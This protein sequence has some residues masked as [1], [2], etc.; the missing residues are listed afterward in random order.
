MDDS[1]P[2]EKMVSL[3]DIQE[4]SLSR[5]RPGAKS[6]SSSGSR[7][8]GRP[9]G[10][11]SCLLCKVRRARGRGNRIEA[12]CTICKFKRLHEIRERPKIVC[13][14]PPVRAEAA[15]SSRGS[16]NR[17]GS[18]EQISAPPAGNERVKE[19]LMGIRADGENIPYLLDEASIAPP[20]SISESTYAEAFLAQP[21][22]PPSTTSNHS[23]ESPRFS[24]RPVSPCL[25]GWM[26]S[27]PAR[28]EPDEVE[29]LQMKGALS[30]PDPNI[31]EAIIQAYVEFVHYDLP[32]LDLQEFLDTISTGEGE[33]RRVSLL[34]FQAIIFAGSAFVDMKCLRNAGFRTRREAR[35][36][37]YNKVRLLYDFDYETDSTNLIQ[38]LLLMTYWYESP[39]DLKGAWHWTGLAASLCR[40]QKLHESSTYINLDTTKQRR[41]KRIWWSC[42][43]RD[44]LVA[45]GTRRP[46][47]IKFEE[48][49]ISMLAMDD[50]NF[51]SA[52]ERAGARCAFGVGKEDASRQQQLALLCIEKVKLCVCIGNILLTQYHIS[53]RHVGKEGP[54]GSEDAT[55]TL[56]PNA[57]DPSHFKSCNDQLQAWSAMLPDVAIY[58]PFDVAGDRLA[59]RSIAAH[60]ALLQMLF[61]TASMTL[62]RP[63]A[64]SG[65][66][67]TE[68]T[69]GAQQQSK[70]TLAGAADAI[71]AIADDLLV[72]DLVW[73]L[74][75]TG[76]TVIASYLATNLLDTTPTDNTTNQK[77]VQQFS[78][79]L[80]AMRILGE[81][82]KA[83]LF[84]IQCVE[85]ATKKRSAPRPPSVMKP[86]PR[87]SRSCNF[88][89]GLSF[90]SIL[91]DLEHLIPPTHAQ[92]PAIPALASGPSVSL[93]TIECAFDSPK[94]VVVMLS[95]AASPTDESPELTMADFSA[96]DPEVG[97]S[98]DFSDSNIVCDEIFN[99]MI[100]FGEPETEEGGVTDSPDRAIRLLGIEEG[101]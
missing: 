10:D 92:A 46:L 72:N 19:G 49:D 6:K 23:A 100:D 3:S 78:I 76:V 7:I 59:T 58:R 51:E 21:V 61:H 35:E 64:L 91:D 28:F 29:F 71:A 17:E 32:V 5:S 101:S 73:Y 62:H 74:P 8:Q 86:Q 36:V 82:Y 12:F 4:Q 67:E 30:I 99:T 47:H 94:D 16:R 98:L 89:P 69:A 63:R 22:S 75:S 83:A 88:G 53:I 79:G 77:R 26:S 80:N 44:R 84:T 2:L 57:R 48:C 9:E 65:A 85:A 54:E 20:A 95:P 38:T 41:L 33:T 34:V 40:R 50:F 55:V 24:A 37:L 25:P 45:L 97:A 18:L 87:P 43:M 81:N 42:F 68:A 27:I 96:D 70:L 1:F 90:Y 14:A 93:D 66:K 11:R 31:R 13:R 15:R 60:L 52:P 56:S 39:N